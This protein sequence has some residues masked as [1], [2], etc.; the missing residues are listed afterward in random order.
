MTGR[1][2]QEG[3][4]GLVDGDH[5]FGPLAEYLVVAYMVVEYVI[6]V[7]G[8]PRRAEGRGAVADLYAAMAM[9]SS[10]TARTN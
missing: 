4:A 6:S 9:S 10:R 3:L 7:P 1:T 2:V 5:F 8:Y